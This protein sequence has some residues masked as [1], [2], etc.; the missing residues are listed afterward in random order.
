MAQL[1]GALTHKYGLCGLRDE[2]L[3]SDG[4][5]LSWIVQNA[6]QLR[7][8]EG[9]AIPAPVISSR[10]PPHSGGVTPG[11]AS[12]G[13]TMPTDAAKDS[14]NLAGDVA[15]PRTVEEVNTA[16]MMAGRRPGAQPGPPSGAG[17][18]RPGWFEQNCPC[19][20]WCC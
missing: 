14:P 3:F 5:T 17:R 12:S 2:L 9:P 19:C 13:G 16:M 8:R 20:M 7:M 6:A 1:G 18:R 15:G 11:H 4:A 10:D